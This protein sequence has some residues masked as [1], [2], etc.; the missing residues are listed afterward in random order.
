MG[1]RGETRE[2]D[3]LRIPDFPD[4]FESE[5]L[6]IRAPEIEDAMDVWNAIGHSLPALRKW[7]PWAQPE[8][9]LHMT[10]ESL[11]K[12]IAQFYHT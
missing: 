8:P 7:M 10:E 4:A 11:R 3:I 6:V 5:R 2:S 12:A 1:R 9:K